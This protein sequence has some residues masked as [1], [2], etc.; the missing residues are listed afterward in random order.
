MMSEVC[1]C[2]IGTHRG[3]EKKKSGLLNTEVGTLGKQE[4]TRELWVLEND[5]LSDPMKMKR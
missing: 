3:D 1:H 4:I 5:A 2:G